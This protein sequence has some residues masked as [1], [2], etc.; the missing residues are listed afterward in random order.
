MSDL[1]Q[2]RRF[3]DVRGMSDLP[4]TA[5]ISGHGRHFAFVPFPDVVL[6]TETRPFSTQAVYSINSSARIR[7]GAGIVIPRAFAV[8]RLISKDSLVTSSIGSALGGV[9][10]NIAS[11]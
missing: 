5:D 4:P 7:I 10:L 9:P 8:L 3:R 2:S 1:G 6:A 11:A